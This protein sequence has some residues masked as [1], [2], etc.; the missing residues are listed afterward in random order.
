[1]DGTASGMMPLCDELSAGSL[2]L[3]LG[4]ATYDFLGRGRCRKNRNHSP[5]AY[6]NQLERVRK[7]LATSVFVLVGHGF[8]ALVAYHYAK[9]HPARVRQTFMVCPIGRNDTSLFR[10][11]R[12]GVIDRQTL[13]NVIP[14]LKNKHAREWESGPPKEWLESLEGTYRSVK[15][16]D[17]LT[18]C[19]KQFRVHDVEYTPVPNAVVLSCEEDKMCSDADA[20]AESLGAAHVRISD[21]RHYCVEERAADVASCVLRLLRNPPSLPARFFLC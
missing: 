9:R 3:D 13:C 17:T 6:V 5:E 12:M 18:R 8:G 11:G 15:F 20:I 7:H 4:V 21:A 10:M 2:S 14:R 1:M 19:L 16:H